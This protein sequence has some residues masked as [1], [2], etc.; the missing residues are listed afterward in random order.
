MSKF[1]Q[2]H[3]FHPFLDQFTFKKGTVYIC[4]FTSKMIKQKL[5]MAQPKKKYVLGREEQSLTQISWSS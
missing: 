2:I 5:Q 3:F 1:S 4:K